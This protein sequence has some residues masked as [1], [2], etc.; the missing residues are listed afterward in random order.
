[1]IFQKDLLKNCCHTSEFGF[2]CFKK[3]LLENLLKISSIFLCCMIKRISVQAHRNRM[4][5]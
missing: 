4:L 3:V 2:L 1:M 5:F